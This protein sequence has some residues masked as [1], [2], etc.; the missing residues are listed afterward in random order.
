MSRKRLTTALA[1]VAVAVGVA[2]S[3][4]LAA[5]P[6]PPK[7]LAAYQACLRKHGI[8]FEG[9]GTRQSPAKLQAA[10]KACAS[11]A[12][13]A[14][15]AGRPPSGFRGQLTKAQRAAFQKYSACLKKH[16]ITLARGSRPAFTS[17]KAKAAQK[18]CAS[19]RP[20]LG[21]P[22]KGTTTATG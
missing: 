2:A 15:A 19:L 4:A 16:G 22:P 3:S 6:T 12:P 5:T 14:A 10:F 21:P 9:T 8:T 1:L 13:Q 20:K 7:T 11:L 18:A 17:A